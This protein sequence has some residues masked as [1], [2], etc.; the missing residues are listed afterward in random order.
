MY[1]RKSYDCLNFLIINNDSILTTVEKKKE[2]KIR[3]R[4]ETVLNPRENVP[5]FA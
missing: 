5:S 1:N 3:R 4:G 2:E